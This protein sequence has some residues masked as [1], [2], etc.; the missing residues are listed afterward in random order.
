MSERWI[1]TELIH[2][3]PEGAVKRGMGNID[4]YVSDSPGLRRYAAR[5]ESVGVIDQG[6]EDIE[7]GS[8]A[9]VQ[10]GLHR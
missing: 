4:F 6:F 5:L 1:S 10:T 8:M 3:R 2:S 7:S 9:N